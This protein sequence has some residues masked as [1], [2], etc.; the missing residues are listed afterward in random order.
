M[1]FSL[2]LLAATAAFAFAAPTLGNAAVQQS[3]D[4]ADKKYQSDPIGGQSIHFSQPGAY[5]AAK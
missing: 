1:K 4:A 2:P 3:D 5:K